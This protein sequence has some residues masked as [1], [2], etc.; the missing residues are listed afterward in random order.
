MPI[1]NKEENNMKLSYSIKKELTEKDIKDILTT[2]LEGGIGYWAELDCTDPAWAAAR[3]R[4]SKKTD[5]RPCWCDVAFEVLN[6]GDA[7]RFIDAEAKDDDNPTEDE[8]FLLT[9]AGLLKG[10]QLWEEH[11]KKDL[12]KTIDECDYDAD[13]ADLIIQ[14]GIFGE[15]IFG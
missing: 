9:M 14:W 6:N 3:K 8:V 10:C 11:S 15:I 1:E 4:W 2:A 12:A 5:E 7:I 13:D